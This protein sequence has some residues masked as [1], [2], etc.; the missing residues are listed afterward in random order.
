MTIAGENGIYEKRDHGKTVQ[1]SF[2]KCIDQSV[3]TSNDC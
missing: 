1:D 2:M 3:Y